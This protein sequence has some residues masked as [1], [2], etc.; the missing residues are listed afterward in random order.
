MKMLQMIKQR[1][2]LGIYSTNNGGILMPDKSRNQVHCMWLRHLI[3]FDEAGRYSWGAAVLAFLFREMCRATNYK[4]TAIDGCLLLLQSWAWFRMPFLCPIVNEPYV[5]P[6]L[7]RW[8]MKRKNHKSIPTGLEE[9]RLLIDTKLRSEFQWIPYASDEVKVCIPPHLSGSLEVWISVIPLICYAIIEWHPVDRVLRQYGCT[10]YIPGV[11]RNLDDVHNIDR[12]GKKEV[13]WVVRHIDWIV[14]WENRYTLLAPRQYYVETGHMVTDNY[15]DWFNKNGK[16][17]LLST[18]ARGVNI[19]RR[20]ERRQPSQYLR[21]PTRGRREG[22][23]GSASVPPQHPYPSMPQGYMPSPP[24]HMPSPPV[25]MPSPQ[26]YISSPQGYIPSPP[27]Y[28]PS[29]QDFIPYGGA[30]TTMFNDLTYGSY[31]SYLAGGASPQ[32]PQSPSG[33]QTS[34]VN[35]STVPGEREDEKT[36]EQVP[37]RNPPRNRQPPPCGTHSRRRHRRAPRNAPSSP[38]RNNRRAPGNAPSSPLR[39]NRRAPGNAPSSPLKMIGQRRLSLLQYRFPTELFPLTYTSFQLSNDDDVSMMV[40]AHMG[41]SQSLIECTTFIESIHIPHDT[42]ASSSREGH[43][44]G[45]LFDLNI[46]LSEEPSSPPEE[47]LREPAELPAHMYEADYDAMYEPEFPDLP[48]VGNYGLQSLVNDGINQ[49][50]PNLDSNIICQAIMPIVKQSSH[51]AVAVLISAIQSQYGYTVSYKKAWLAKQN[52]ICKLHGEWD[53]SYNKLPSWFHVVQ[54]LNPGTI[55][56]FET[57]HHYVN[58]RMVRGRCQFY[59]VFWTYPQCIN[60]VKYCKPVVQIDGT[61]LY[62]KYKQVLLLVVVQDGNRNILP[63]AFALVQGED[64]ESWVF[65][66]KNLRL[67][68]VTRERVCIISGRDKNNGPL[69]TMDRPP[70]VQHRY[71]VRHIAANYYGKYKKNDERQLVVRMGYELLPQRFESMLQELFGKNKKGCEYIIDISKEMWTNA[72]D[73]GVAVSHQNPV[74]ARPG[75]APS[76]C[77]IQLS[78]NTAELFVNGEM[79]KGPRKTEEV[80]PQPQRAQDRPRGGWNHSPRGPK[81]DQGTTT[82]P[83]M[84]VECAETYYYKRIGV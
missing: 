77:G 73:G 13:N 4:K 15:M 66:L 11:P 45:N 28:M 19:P 30:Y 41:S 79:F 82:G 36:E 6:L 33:S 47:P 57:Q 12:R 75:D 54:R 39:N 78:E 27:G 67:H 24:L 35:V 50:H 42:M 60:A 53:S 72:Y 18:E 26:G 40:D 44:S 76:T 1:H 8:S 68:V 29:P 51:I 61:F 64:T 3:D 46:G 65:F 84:H 14:L 63:V 74:K 23:T 49:D 55:V 20:R 21:P 83:A 48:D 5:F 10:Q 38:L 62:G 43:A 22:A 34:M 69:G 80:E 37:R 70:H 9:I 59:R 58:D 7:L 56:E 31:A 52:A 71:C 25:H 17:F 32:T 16:P 2:V 81:T